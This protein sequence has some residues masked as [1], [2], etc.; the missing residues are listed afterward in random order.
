LWTLLFLKAGSGAENAFV[1]S[2]FIRLSYT[3][4]FSL[5]RLEH[6]QKVLDSM[7]KL[8]AAGL[9]F[10]RREHLIDKHPEMDYK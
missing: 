1:D 10:N 2:L 3:H 6:A 5:C 7:G 8:H 4:G 9:V